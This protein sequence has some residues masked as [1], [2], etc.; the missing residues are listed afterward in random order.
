MTVTLES[1]ATCFQGL[2]PAQFFTCSSDGV[3]NSAYLSHVDYV[4]SQHVALSFQFFNK[5]KH[6]IGENPNALVLV[7]D[8]DTGQGWRLRLRYVRSETSG[9]L[10]ERM[11]LRIEAIASYCGLKGI[12]KLRASDVYEVLSVE[13]A[14]EEPGRRRSGFSTSSPR[15]RASPTSASS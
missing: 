15:E 12:F 3:P 1:L 10:F 8:P 5:S 2:L 9:A 13:P 11:A 7:Q 14:P 6:N 4:D